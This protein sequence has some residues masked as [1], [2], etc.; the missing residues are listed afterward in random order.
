MMEYNST[1]S[2]IHI[3]QPYWYSW[4]VKDT[5]TTWS[6]HSRLNLWAGRFEKKNKKKDFQRFLL[7]FGITL[8]VVPQQCGS[9]ERWTQQVTYNWSNQHVCLMTFVEWDTASMS[10]PELLW[11]WFW[12]NQSFIH[13]LEMHKMYFHNEIS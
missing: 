9:C 5:S 6:W 2:I 4:E 3:K 13:W 7:E 11:Y 1:H 8:S 10:L 12:N